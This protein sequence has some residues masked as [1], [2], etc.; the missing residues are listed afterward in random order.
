MKQIDKE[1]KFYSDQWPKSK[2]IVEWWGG[3]EKEEVAEREFKY[4]GLDNPNDN[5]NK[6]IAELP[7]FENMTYKLNKYGYRSDEFDELKDTKKPKF[8]FLG[9]SFAFGQGIPEET[10]VSKI[11]ANE[12]NAVHWNLSRVGG[13]MEGCLLQLNTF[14]DAGYKPDKVIAFYPLKDRQIFVGDDMFVEFH[15]E[16]YSKQHKHWLISSNETMNSWNWWLCAKAIQ[17]L[18]YEHNIDLIETSFDQS[19]LKILP[20]VLNLRGYYSNLR[21]LT[22]NEMYA[23]DGIHP[24]I[25]VNKLLSNVLIEHIKGLKPKDPVLNAI[26]NPLF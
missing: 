19:Y 23:R 11:I 26:T 20:H 6:E 1:S 14:L 21:A 10:M 24:G 9:C 3:F 8:L 18:C 25:A 7:E 12:F 5:W 22:Q 13:N 2:G 17:S 15:K 4:Y 16:I